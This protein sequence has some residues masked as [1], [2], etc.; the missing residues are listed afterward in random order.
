MKAAF[1]SRNQFNPGKIATLLKGLL[2]E[3]RATLDDQA[4]VLAGRY[5]YVDAAHKVV[6]DV[7]YVGSKDLASY[8]IT[9]PEGHVLINSGFERTVP[10]RT[11]IRGWCGRLRMGII[12]RAGE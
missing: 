1:D 9:T 3:Y 7:Y 10:A 4:A 2:D 11:A 6:G 5:H 8:L 12:S